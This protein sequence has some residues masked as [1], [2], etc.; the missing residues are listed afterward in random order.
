[1]RGQAPLIAMRLQHRKPTWVSVS[2]DG[3][4]WLAN[5]WHE[6]KGLIPHLLIEPDDVLERLDLRC[7]YG[8]Q[9][10]VD[11]GNA[12]R[13]KAVYEAC[14]QAGAIRV[15]GAIHRPKGEGLEIVEYLDT[16]GVL[17]WQT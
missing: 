3:G 10:D 13:V 8:L 15:L 1:M 2:T 7:L 17:T 16:A 5:H 11:G 4:P 12:A 14:V 6:W 9:I